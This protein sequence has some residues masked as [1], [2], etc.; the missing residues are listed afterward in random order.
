MAERAGKGAP[1]LRVAIAGLGAAGCM[2]IPALLKHPQV[3]IAAAADLD[4]EALGKFQRDFQAETHRSVKDLCKNPNVDAIYIATPT[5]YHI[6]HALMALERRKHVVLEKPMALTL[7]DAD[8]I[9][10]AAGRSGVQLVV[11]HSHSFELPIRKLRE[12]VRSGELGRL[13]MLHNWYFT[14]WLYRPRHAEELDT[15]L[16]GGVTFRQGSHQ[17]D[18]LRMIGGGLVRSVRAMTGV[19]DARRPTEGHHVVY[20]EFEDGTPATAVYSGYDRFHTTE[21]TLGIGEQGQLMDASVYGRARKTLESIGGADQEAALKRS[22]VRYGGAL[23]RPVS[24]TAPHPPFYGLTIVSCEHGD[25]RQ[26]AHGLFVYGTQEKREIP[27]RT[28]ETGRDAVVSELYEAAVNGRQPAHGGRWGKANLE[29]CL[30]VL[31]S[32]SA[33]QEVFLAHQTPTLDATA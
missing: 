17:F 9:I 22:L 4:Q 10:A 21:L 18:L 14:D 1:I 8:A 23:A 25:I 15:Q 16:G 13:R 29:V 27:L 30:A 24:G 20:L 32:A 31:A 33:R 19:W 7:A 26:S 3:K 6:E 12:I 5:Q 28:H 11:G 2:M